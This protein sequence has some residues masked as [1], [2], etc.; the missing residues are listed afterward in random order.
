MVR[1]YTPC[2]GFLGTIR[3]CP[4]EIRA[5]EK[6]P[7]GNE[8]CRLKTLFPCQLGNLV[9]APPPTPPARTETRSMRRILGESLSILGWLVPANSEKISR[10]ITN[11]P[12]K[13]IGALPFVILCYRRAPNCI[14]RSAFSHPQMSLA[15]LEDSTHSTRWRLVRC[16]S[17]QALLGPAPQARFARSGR[18][19]RGH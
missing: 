19:A 2:A 11:A 1:E 15:G 4:L 16:Q 18:A 12:P 8:I 9:S 10:S 14:R 5:S 13:A 3:N 6:V 7:V 17:P